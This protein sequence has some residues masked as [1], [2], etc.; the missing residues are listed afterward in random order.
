M[1][2]QVDLDKLFGALQADVPQM[3]DDLMARILADAMAN[4]PKPAAP[5]AVVAAPP[6]VRRGFWAGFAALF[7]GAGALAGIGSAAVAGLVV[8][9][10]QPAGLTSLADAVLGTPLETV[11][12]IP[13]VDAL[14]AEE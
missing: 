10:V 13:S 5:V 3:S 4:Q 12:M 7:G 9:F 8:G 11:E 2:D 14:W 1:Q 6:V